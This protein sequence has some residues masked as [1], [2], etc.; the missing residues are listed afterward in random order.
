MFDRPIRL[1]ARVLNLLVGG[2]LLAIVCI[3]LAQ[4]VA[5]YALGASLV[6]SEELTR[7]L[8]LWMV[9][10]AAVGGAHMRIGLVDR[11]LSRGLQRGLLLAS[12]ALC[13]V[14][15]V[16]LVRGSWNMADLVRY[17]R[18]T[19]VD[20][21]VSLAFQAFVVG[22]AAWALALVGETVRR[23]RAPGAGEAPR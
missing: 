11:H 3:T 2:L 23:W 12:S 7:L 21:P 4:V 14:M 1:A 13:L 15:L 8:H 22:G 20:L 18:Y 16:I 5:R 17:D 6:W 10:L 9:A 19:G